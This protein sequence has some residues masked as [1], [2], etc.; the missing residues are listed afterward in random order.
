MFR[1]TQG[2]VFGSLLEP[3]ADAIAAYE[4]APRVTETID[5]PLTTL[6]DLV[7]ER[8]VSLLK[9]DVQGAEIQVIEGVELTLGR[10]DAII[11]EMNF[12]SLYEN[13]ATVG[14]L[15]DAL[16]ARG[17]TLWDMAA[18]ARVGSGPLSYADVCYVRATH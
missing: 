6:D 15:H 9:L 13:G 7:G 8:R 11:A 3:T 17:F 14:S 16:G 5:V 10:T 4:Q 18:P 1:V 12:M 2:D